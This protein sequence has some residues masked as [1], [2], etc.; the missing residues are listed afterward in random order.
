MNVP[1]AILPP[2]AI[3]LV[4]IVRYILSS[5]L[6]SSSSFRAVYVTAL[7]EEQEPAFVLAI[8]KFVSKCNPNT[9]QHFT[10]LLYRICTKKPV[11]LD[12]IGLYNSPYGDF[13]KVRVLRIL[14]WPPHKP[15]RSLFN[16]MLDF[17]SPSIG[18]ILELFPEAK[19]H[20]FI[21]LYCRRELI[22]DA[23]G[24]R[25]AMI[26]SILAPEIPL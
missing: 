15:G 17:S 5:V 13:K 7:T 16:H 10:K 19:D 18:F 26:R 11:E 24:K 12:I 6:F 2:Y 4:R 9:F 22:Q 3:R 1:N 8:S 23:S 14:H 25:K 21:D 20:A